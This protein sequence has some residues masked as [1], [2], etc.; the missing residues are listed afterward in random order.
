MKKVRINVSGQVQGVGFR[1][2]TKAAA[3]KIGV[4]GAV[5][6]EA[7][8]SV[9]IEAMGTEVQIELFSKMVKSGLSPRGQVDCFVIE[10]APEIKERLNFEIIRG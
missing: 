2:M 10:E 5:W 4:K 6:N 3:D 9:S 8:G 7:N 1:Y